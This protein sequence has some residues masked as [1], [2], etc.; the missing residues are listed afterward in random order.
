MLNRLEAASPGSKL[1]FV[2][3]F[4]HTRRSRA[5]TPAT[6][7]PPQTCEGC[8]MPSFG[9]LCGFCRLVRETQS[10]RERRR[11]AEPA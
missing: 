1:T 8:G 7:A 3:E 4:L 9:A 5:L 10:R 2:Q 11:A 6:I